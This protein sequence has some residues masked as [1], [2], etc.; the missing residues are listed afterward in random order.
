MISIPRSCPPDPY[1]MLP[2]VSAIT[3][4]EV[5]HPTELDGIVADQQRDHANNCRRTWSSLVRYDAHGY[6]RSIHAEIRSRAL[7]NVR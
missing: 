6:A 7:L 3:Q 5:F 4:L 2:T 1:R